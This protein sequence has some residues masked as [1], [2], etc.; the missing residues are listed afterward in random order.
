MTPGLQDQ[1]VIYLVYVGVA[2]GVFL[3]VTGLGQLLTRGE[4]AAEARN[5]RMKMIGRGASTEEVLALLKAPEDS[6]LLRRI[7][8]LGN[9]AREMR[10]AG[11]TMSPAHLLLFCLLG[12]VALGL[13]AVRVLPPI[14]AFAV[15]I[16]VSLLLPVA[17]VGAKR[18]KRVEAL[19]AQL[20]DALD[21]MS[22]GL[23]V[24]HPLNTSIGAVAKEMPDPVGTEFGLIFDQVS[25]GDDLVAAVQE[26]AQRVDIEDVH[27]LAASIAIQHGTGGDLAR[28][29][30]VMAKV[31]RG[32]IAMRRRIRAISSEGR[33]SAWFLSAIPVAIY[34]FTSISSPTYFGGVIADPLYVPMMSVIVVLV[35]TNALVL[36][37]LVNF[38]I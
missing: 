33:L 9:L 28:V 25:Y 16:G 12:G 4:N 5:R 31:I 34:T 29:I 36:R 38:R 37:K 6:G 15:A 18:R 35:V 10:R 20:P 3:L 2:L 21:L 30:E 17:V 23:K 32:R 27:Y 22:R 19:V 7:P 13:F 11:M 24:G 1:E 8:V 14:Q 26:F